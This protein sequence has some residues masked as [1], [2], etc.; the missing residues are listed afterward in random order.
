ME[1]KGTSKRDKV[2]GKGRIGGVRNFKN[3]KGY[4]SDS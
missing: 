4:E 1:A 2:D 3:T